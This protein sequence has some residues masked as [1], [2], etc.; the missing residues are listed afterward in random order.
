MT[1]IP[2]NKLT[3]WP[4]DVRKTGASDGIEELAASIAAHGLLQS[5]VVRKAARGKF[6]VIAGQR[7]FLALSALAERDQVPADLPVECRLIEGD[8][9]AAEIGLAENVVRQAMHPADQFEAFRN[10]IDKGSSAADVAARFGVSE[11]IVAKRLKLGRVSLSIL[12]AYRRG[13]LGLEQVQ[14]F[15]VSD[16]HAAQESVWSQRATANPNAIRRALTEGEVP[17]TDRRACLVGLE[18]YEAAGGIVRRDLFDDE[19]GGY[20]QDAGLLDQLVHQKLDT[21]AQ[22]VQA[23]GWKWTQTHPDFDYKTRAQFRRCYPEQL[24]LSESDEAE[25]DQLEAERDDLQDAQCNE[26]NEDGDDNHAVTARL[27]EIDARIDEITDHARSWTAEIMSTAGAVITLSSDG[28]AEVERG[29]VRPEDVPGRASEADETD[30]AAEEAPA[31][32]L[33]AKL[34]TDLTAQ[35]TAALRAAL[36]EQPDVALA[37]V[38]HA[39]A[40]Q[41]F[42]TSGGETCL[43]ITATRRA[44]TMPIAQ[45]GQCSGLSTFEADR[46]RWGDRLQGNPDDLFAW[47]LEQ[48]QDFLLHLLAISVA[49]TVDAVREKGTRE[50][51]P[52]LIHADALA[53]ALAFDMNAWFTPTAA[54]YFGRVSRAFIMDALVEAGR[55]V[56]TRSWSK[57]KKAELAALAERHVRRQ[58]PVDLCLPT[59][60]LGA[61]LNLPLI[62]KRRLPRPK[63]LAEVLSVF[64]PL[65]WA[66]FGLRHQDSSCCQDSE[67]NRGFP[68]MSPAPHCR[69]TMLA[70]S[71]S[72]S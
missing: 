66:S 18:A 65:S 24:P 49:H 2:L 15:S 5:L 35:R 71:R 20:L 39:F 54:N 34:V 61:W 13:E 68:H 27:E 46:E 69:G 59:P 19:G 45:P 38:T 58:Q 48:T 52:R 28:E 41:A 26:D 47:C 3:S 8:I 36:A 22:T 50:K 11:G 4:D 64:A 30:D 21:L 17:F 42:Y 51:A 14:A 63:H 9:D 10:L 31:P 67:D 6:T 43:D 1:T 40:R 57:L 56:R 53:K 12:D 25:R 23:E 7:R 44:L 32:S 62:R 55:P 72:A 16:D 37:A 33:S 70:H 29:L 60:E